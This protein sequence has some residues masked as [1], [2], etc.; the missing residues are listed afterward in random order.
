LSRE[1]DTY[2]PLSEHG[3]DHHHQND[4]SLARSTANRQT[5]PIIS[6]NHCPCF[7]IRYQLKRHVSKPT[8][9]RFQAVP[10]L[11]GNSLN[12]GA[13]RRPIRPAACLKLRDRSE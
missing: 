13:Q 12:S 1:T 6:K 2:T 11:L 7:L 4:K 8:L 3:A 5:E 9:E 10:K